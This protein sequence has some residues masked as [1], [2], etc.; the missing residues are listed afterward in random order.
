MRL[1][2]KGSALHRRWRQLRRRVRQWGAPPRPLHVALRRFAEQNREVIFVQ[3]G[4]NDGKTGD[5]IYRLGRRHRWSGILV[6]PVPYL[7]EQLRRNYAGNDRVVIENCAVAETDGM[8]DFWYVNRTHGMRD[9]Y[10][11]IGSF[12]REHLVK[13]TKYISNIESFLVKQAVPCLTLETLIRKHSL[14][15]VDLLHVDAEGYD[16]VII[17]SIDFRTLRPRFLFY[18]HVHIPSEERR[19]C[20]ELLGRQGYTVFE[21]SWDTFALLDDSSSGSSTPEATS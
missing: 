20:K 4:S 14:P 10:D 11:Q 9:W 7:V 8:R 6:E 12:D 2:S 13:H 15:R 18:E 19:A 1:I 21:D 5:P 3:V 17:R 16:H